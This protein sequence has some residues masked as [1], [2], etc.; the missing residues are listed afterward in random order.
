V[1]NLGKYNKFWASCGQTVGALIAVFGSRIGLTEG[2]S[3]QIGLSLVTIFNAL[4][5]TL[6]NRKSGTDLAPDPS[7]G[8]QQ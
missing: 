1:E 4:V 2:E 5:Y 6:R 3:A 8:K 7:I